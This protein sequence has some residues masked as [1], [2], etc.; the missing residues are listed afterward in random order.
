MPGTTTSHAVGLAPTKAL[1]QRV[2]GVL[3]SPRET[4]ADVAAQPHSMAVLLLVMAVFALTFG[5][6][7]STELGQILALDQQIRRT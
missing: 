7:L 2:L 3:M 5:V 4:Y 1:P 6:F